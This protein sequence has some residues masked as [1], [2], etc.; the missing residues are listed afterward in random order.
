[1][2][3][4]NFLLLRLLLMGGCLSLGFV[5]CAAFGWAAKQAPQYAMLLLCVLGFLVYVRVRK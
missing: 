3:R 4:I 2:S 1:M 5:A